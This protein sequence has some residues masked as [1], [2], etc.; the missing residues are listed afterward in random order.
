MST[1]AHDPTVVRLNPD[2]TDP[3][4]IEESIDRGRDTHR[5]IPAHYRDAV[6]DVPEVAGWVRA[7]VETAEAERRTVPRIVT[8]PSLLLVGPTGTGKT[9]QAYGAI[10]ALTVSGAACS[11]Q[12]LTAANLYAQLRPRHQVDSEAVFDAIA[13]VGVLVVDDLGAAKGS[14]WNEEIN[15]RLINHRYEHELPTL[16]TS[17]VPTKELVSALGER[18]AS[19]LVEMASRV[20]LHGTDRRLGGVA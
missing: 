9:F 15:Y 10:R 5:R 11:W 20:V 6:A 7:L 2:R 12:A 3:H 4:W 19:R 18:V 16:I 17:N 1:E 8:G 13:N 14:E